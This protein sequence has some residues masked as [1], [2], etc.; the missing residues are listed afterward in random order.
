MAGIANYI[1]ESYNELKNHVTW[2]SYAE[3]Q[4]L[5]VIVLVFSVIFAL[6]VWGVDTV[7]SSAIEQYFNWVKS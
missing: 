1:S 5:T 3:A 4:R 6:L 2:P 7:F